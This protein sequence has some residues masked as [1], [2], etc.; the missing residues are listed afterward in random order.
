MSPRVHSILAP[1]LYL[2]SLAGTHRNPYSK[3]ISGRVSFETLAEE[4]LD[5]KVADQFFTH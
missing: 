4:A 2:D 1:T 5:K 3:E